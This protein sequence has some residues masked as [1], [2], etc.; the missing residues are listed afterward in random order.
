VP[1]PLQRKPSQKGKLNE[2]SKTAVKPENPGKVDITRVM[3]SSKALGQ[4]IKKP[5]KLKIKNV[6]PKKEQDKQEDPKPSG[7]L[8][9]LDYSLLKD[10]GLTDIINNNSPIE[11]RKSP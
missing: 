10:L 5:I 7:D 6:S 8:Y 11:E 4:S 9:G 2:I 1:I 3:A